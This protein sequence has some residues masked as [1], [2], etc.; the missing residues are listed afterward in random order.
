MRKVDQHEAAATEIAGVGINDGQRKAG[1]DCRIDSIAAL[2]QDADARI[3]G[4]VMN[5]DD[6]C[7]FCTDRLFLL[8]VWYSR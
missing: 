1:R 6:H 5:A 2:L 8:P 7:M 3:C 4:Q